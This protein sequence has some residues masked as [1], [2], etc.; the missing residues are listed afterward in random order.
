MEACGR[1]K[2]RQIAETV[3]L[4]TFGGHKRR[5]VATNG[6]IGVGKSSVCGAAS[7]AAN[8]GGVEGDSAGKWRLCGAGKR[9]LRLPTKPDPE[10]VSAG[11][12][13]GPGVSQWHTSVTVVSAWQPECIIMALASCNLKSRCKPAAADVHAAGPGLR[14]PG[15]VFINFVVAM[16]GALSAGPGSRANLNHCTAA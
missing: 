14:V 7:I 2:C 15:R 9:P 4:V 3:A 5:P 10:L 13:V 11:P 6:G 1:H 12:R 16:L 8:G